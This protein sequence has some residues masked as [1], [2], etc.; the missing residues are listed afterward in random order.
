MKPPAIEQAISIYLPEKLKKAVNQLIID[1]P[2]EIKDFR[3]DSLFYLL[4]LI[5][6]IQAYNKDNDRIKNG[7]IILNSVLMKKHVRNYNKYFEYL[8]SHGIVLTDNH[9]IVKSKSKGFKIAKKYQ[10]LVVETKLHNPTLRKAI[11][12][13]TWKDLGNATQYKTLYRYLTGIEIDYNLAIKF[14]TNQKDFRISQ[15]K[16]LKG[17]NKIQSVKGPIN[18]F[19]WSYISISHLKNNHFHF[20]VD[21]NIHRLH[22]NLT[23]LNSDLR[24]F[25][26]WRG[27]K[28]VSIDISNSQP[29]LSTILLSPSFYT[30]ETTIVEKRKR[31]SMQDRLTIASFPKELNE[32]MVNYSYR[33]DFLLSHFLNTVSHYQNS[34]PFYSPAHSIT[35]NDKQEPN[36][37]SDVLLYRQLV[38]K[39]ILYEYLAEHFKKNLGLQINDRKKIKAIVFQ[40]LFTDNRF[41]GQKD[42]APKRLFKELFPNVYNLFS[43]YKKNDASLLP[44]LLQHIES[45]LIL[46]VIVK[47]IVT[48]RPKI[49]IFTIHDSIATTIPNLIFIK[50]TMASELNKYIGIKPNFKIEYWDEATLIKNYPLLYKENKFH[51]QA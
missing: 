42:A 11:L 13:S 16:Q 10:G 26:T 51:L 45:K 21:S 43:M 9:Y 34:L 19:N 20:S 46:D 39:G 23:N 12:K 27:Q 38:E 7:Y 1:F 41:I 14:I 5:Y 40:V 48:K 2:P 22:T 47:K 29:F 8:I 30:T 31:L 17:E 33:Q 15:L 4:N 6:E 24:N 18:K 32:L 37:Q 50:N 25:L 44:R 3:R 28:L 36:N 35:L 49:P